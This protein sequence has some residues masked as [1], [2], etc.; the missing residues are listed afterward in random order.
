MKT[1][2]ISED[3]YKAILEAAFFKGCISTGKDM[4]K[5]LDDTLKAALKTIR[6]QQFVYED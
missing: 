5:N 1:Y 6:N 3:L 4:D 2:T